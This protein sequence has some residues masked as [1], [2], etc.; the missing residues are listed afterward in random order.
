MCRVFFNSRVILSDLISSPIECVLFV[1]GD[2][3]ADLICCPINLGHL[4]GFI[5]I[6]LSFHGFMKVQFKGSS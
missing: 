5:F 1:S 4:M 3:L 6:F 2:D